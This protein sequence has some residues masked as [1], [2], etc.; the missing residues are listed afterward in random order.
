MANRRYKPRLKRGI[1]EN[2]SFTLS[3]KNLKL[4]RKRKW[5]TLSKNFTNNLSSE[6][7]IR[8]DVLL[9]QSNTFDLRKSFKRALILKQQTSAFF[10][11]FRKKGLHNVFS[12]GVGLKSVCDLLELRLDMVLVR[13]KLVKTLNH[14]RWCISSGFVSVNN[15]AV[16]VQPHSLYVGD[17]IRLNCKEKELFNSAVFNLPPDYLEVNYSVLSVVVVNRP[18][19][20]NE[21]EITKLYPFFLGLDE[22][23]NFNRIN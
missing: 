10:C 4:L 20:K 23:A 1:L 21:N 18:S 12:S 3:T 8:N 19:L 6:P 9:I 2:K 11:T 15:T 16:R 22:I 5:G 7:F 13:S 17:L 14:A